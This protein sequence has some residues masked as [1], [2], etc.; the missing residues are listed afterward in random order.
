MYHIIMAHNVHVQF[1]NRQLQQ[2]TPHRACR[3][4]TRDKMQCVMAMATSIVF[5]GS[6]P[7]GEVLTSTDSL[8]D[9]GMISRFPQPGRCLMRGS[10]APLHALAVT[11]SKLVC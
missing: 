4:V 2:Q 10:P 3:M 1:Q 11:R 8:I 7:Y 6:M 5:H 9:I